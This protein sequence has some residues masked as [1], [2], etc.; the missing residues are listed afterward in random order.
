[1]ST[2][3]RESMVRVDTEHL[4]IAK[5]IAGLKGMTIKD[6]FGVKV[7]EDALNL[8]NE[9]LKHLPVERTLPPKRRGNV[10]LDIIVMFICLGVLGMIFLFM[11]PPLKTALTNIGQTTNLTTQGQRNLE[12]TRDVFPSLYDSAFVFFFLGVWIFFLISAYFIE[13]HPIFFIITLII[14]IIALLVIPI[15]G[16]AVSGVG[17][18]STQQASFPYIIFILNHF[19]ELCLLVFFTVV[20]ALF[21][22]NKNR[23]AVL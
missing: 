22:R 14:M 11:Y 16:N 8:P 17:N 20:I 9:F 13:N 1:M 2:R 23:G 5:S 6:Y 21:A 19:L 12:N 10:A 18:T 7:E 15:I 4:R 3:R